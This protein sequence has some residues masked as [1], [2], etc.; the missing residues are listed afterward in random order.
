MHRLKFLIAPIMAWL[1]FT[2][3]VSSVASAEIDWSR[4][5]FGRW[6]IVSHED[7]SPN[8]SHDYPNTLADA[9]VGKELLIGADGISM[10]QQFLWF[11]NKQTSICKENPSI[12]QEDVAEVARRNP[13]YTSFMYK[14]NGPEKASFLRVACEG[15]VIAAQF[16]ETKAVIYWDNRYF[17]LVR[18]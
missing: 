15:F 17:W 3:L 11:G 16:Y 4:Q 12:I 8:V 9:Q 13:L 6:E 1:C 14:G 5:A 18:K 2:L 10:D 7:R